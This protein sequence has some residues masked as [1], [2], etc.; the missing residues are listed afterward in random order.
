MSH[1]FFDDV[2]IAEHIGRGNMK[3]TKHILSCRVEIKRLWAKQTGN[4]D[5]HWYFLSG[6]EN[7]WKNILTG[8]ELSCNQRGDTKENWNG[9]STARELTMVEQNNFQ[10]N[11][12][13]DASMLDKQVMWATSNTNLR[14]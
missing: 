10:N 14:E 5:A 13:P 4:D 3:T 6:N 9:E 1:F 12:Q 11:N 2:H 8:Y 7:H